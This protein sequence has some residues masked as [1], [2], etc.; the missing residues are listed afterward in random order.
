ML[1]HYYEM[2]FIVLALQPLLFSSGLFLLALS[3]AMIP[4][5]SIDFFYDDPNWHAFAISI[6]VTIFS[7][8]LLVFA[9]RPVGPIKLSVRDTFLL[10]ALNWL[11]VAFYSALPFIFSNSTTTLTDSFFE[12]IS[13]L[14]TTGASVI[15][16][17]DLTSPG[18]VL[19]RSL[20]QW[21]GGIGIIIMALTVMPI[22]RIGGMQLFRN[23]FSDRS[24]KILPHVSQ[25]ANAILSTY[26]AFTL[27]C[28]ALLWLAGMDI[29]DAVC[30]AL[31]TISTGGFSTVSTSI[32]S[33][34]N[35]LV[36]IIMIIFMLVGGITL[37][38]FVKFFQGDFK[39][40]FLDSQVRV[41][42]GIAALSSLALTLWRYNEGVP[43]IKALRESTFNAVSVLTTTG[44]SSTDYHLW[45]S[46]P[47]MIFFTLMMLGGC[48]G[49]T[50]GGI[51]IFRYQIM[52]SVA[53][54]QFAQLRRPH[55]IFLPTYNKST[56]P[57][58]IFTSVFTFFA[59]F[60]ICVGLM[61]LTLSLYGLDF[62][63][64]CSAAVASLNNIGPGLGSLIGPDA[65]Y[66]FLPDS[67]KW[68]L[69]I[70][71]VLGRLEYVTILILL[72]PGFWRD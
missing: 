24:E 39:S 42:L 41:F 61:S 9:N 25:I 47:V 29:L 8:L 65:T 18:I 38:L 33:F 15:E 62:I 67:A 7:G 45:G 37:I 14:T 66:S 57:E 13:G 12:A 49:S 30:H 20:L 46:F 19:W 10:T 53:R 50:S 36:E 70:G 17:L 32:A 72:S 71:M 48:T 27:L 56:I 26:V 31:S 4:P 34:D 69:M 55:G 64:A 5:L 43:F 40:L 21:F 58:G 63:T 16:G 28:G 54:S 23:E 51:K 60:V 1:F 44:Y 35:P 22:L 68:I 2:G 3:A 52:F 11:I 6:A 59:L